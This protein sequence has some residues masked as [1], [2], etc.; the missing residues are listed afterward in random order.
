MTKQKSDLLDELIWLEPTAEFEIRYLK[1]SKLL[2]EIRPIE[3]WEYAEGVA[4]LCEKISKMYPW[5]KRAV[6]ESLVLQ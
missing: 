2:Q 6:A 1:Y 5:R 3:G 4:E